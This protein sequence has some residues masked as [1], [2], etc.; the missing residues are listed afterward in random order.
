M[1]NGQRNLVRSLLNLFEVDFGAHWI[2]YSQEMTEHNE[3]YIYFVSFFCILLVTC[4]LRMMDSLGF[5]LTLTVFP[6]TRLP[7]ASLVPMSDCFP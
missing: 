6:K 7:L 2:S 4:N 3:H 1:M 5:M